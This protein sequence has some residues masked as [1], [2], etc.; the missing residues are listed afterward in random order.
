MTTQ[1]PHFIDG[2]RSAGSSTRTADVLNPSTG[3][4]QAAV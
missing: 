4:V 3:E 1:I 2:Q